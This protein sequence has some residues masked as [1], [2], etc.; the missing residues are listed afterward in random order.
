[1]ELLLK[2][3]GPCFNISCTT[4]NDVRMVYCAFCKNLLRETCIEC[5]EA[6]K[7][8][9]NDLQFIEDVKD[10]RENLM[11]IYWVLYIKLG[12][13]K[14]VV[15]LI[16]TKYLNFFT[17]I[18]RT[19]PIIKGKCNHIYHQHC[20][21]KWTKKRA[22]CPLDQEIWEKKDTDHIVK[23]TFLPKLK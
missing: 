23:V 3:T 7:P 4:S 2:N 15:K 14:N 17:F 6:K 20:I 13:K 16:I 9:V 18:E 22:D 10:T 11:Y 5:C 19:C 1:M 8:L 12:G 21:S